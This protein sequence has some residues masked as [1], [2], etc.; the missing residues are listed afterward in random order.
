LAEL[1]EKGNLGAKTGEGFYQYSEEELSQT[2]AQRDRVL[3]WVPPIFMCKCTL[4]N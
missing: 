1:V 4:R 2:I 3:L